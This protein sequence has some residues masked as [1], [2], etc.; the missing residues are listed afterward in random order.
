MENVIKKMENV[1]D[2]S[3]CSE[4]Q[5]VKY[6][7]SLFV[8]KA[9]TWW[10]T[11]IQARGREAAIVT[12]DSSRIKRYITGLAPEIRGMLR[13]TQPTT[14]QSVI[15]RPGILTDEAVSCGTLTKGN[16]KR[17]GV[18]ETSKSGGSWKENK[19]EK[20]RTGFVATTPPRNEYVSPYLKCARQ[21]DHVNAVRMGNNQRICYECGSSDHLRNTSKGRAF[22]VNVNTVE[23]LHDPNVVTGTFSL[24]NHFATVLFDSGADFSFIYTEFAPLL[25]VKSSIVNPGYVIEV[26]DGKKVKVDRII[27][28]YKLELGNSLFSINLILLGHGSFD[29]IVGMDWLSQ[30]KIVIVCHE[31]VVE[32]PLEDSG[33]PRGTYFR[34]RQS[35]NECKCSEPK[36]SD[37]L[38]KEEHEVHSRLALE[39]LKREKLYAK[40]SKCEFWLQEVRFLGHMVNQNGI[41]MDPSKI[42]AVKN[43]KDPTTPSK[44]RSFLGLAGYYRCFIANFSKIAKPLTLLTQKNKKR[45][46][47]YGTK[48]VIYMDHKSLQHIFDQ[49]ELNMRQRGWIELF[50][51]Y[52]CEIRYHPVKRNDTGSQKKE[53]ES[54][55]FMD[56]IWVP[57][58]GG[59][60]TIIMDEAHKTK[61]S[62]NP[63]A[64]KMYHDLR[65]MYWWLGKK[66]DIAAYV[67]KC[68]TCS[69]VKDKHQRWVED[70][71]VYCDASNQGLGKVNVVA[72]ALSR[73][74]RVK[75]RR[76]QAM[77]MT[78]QPGI[79]GMILVARGEAFKKE[80]V[81]A[82]KLHGLDQQMERKED[83]SFYFMDLIWVPLVGGVRMKIM[84]KA[85]K[86]RSSVKAEHQRPSGLLKQPEI[87]E[88][89]WDKIIMDFITKLPKTKSGHDTIWVIVD[90]LTKSAHFQARLEDYSTERLAKLYIDE[91][92]ARHGVPDV[93][94]PLAKFSYNNSYNSSIWCAPFEALY[95]RK[96]RSPVLWAEISESSLIRPEL[97]QETTDKPLEIEVG[98]RVLLKVSLWKGVIR[99]GKKGKLALRYVGPFKVLERIGPVAYRLRLPEEL[100]GVH[101]TFHV[102]NLKKCLADANLHVPLNEIKVNNTLRLVKE[103]VEIMGHEIKSLKRSRIKLVKV[104]WNSKRGPEFT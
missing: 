96:C 76:A 13:A 19:K 70:F 65:D 67:S 71:V 40:F 41:H 60:R 79:R 16:E 56:R 48:S 93:H 22:N 1:I 98:D 30:N 97:V 46:Y 14:I 23:A 103:P 102:S 90:R 78:I 3:E 99:F 10:N 49:K 2:N 4:N 37:I 92:V 53:D 24:N 73:K 55:Y 104:R 95:G 61:Y 64:D 43:W 51:D 87:P 72:D 33:I 17:K 75:P 58:V 83:G 74:E 36:L 5:K 54:L 84:D 62:I 15:L 59:V 39:L 77:D 6:A 12:P 9:L 68:L 26:V 7:A 31:K 25:N 8:N 82:E 42:K 66:R 21:V 11:Q 20:V 89:K 80:N 27:R 86:T 57:L 85:H 91:I 47:L 29:V 63:G 45:H 50:S 101:D 34:S 88:W 100:S 28:D 81:L 32:I 18:E 38:S 44:I 52:E 35:L 69:K 94:L